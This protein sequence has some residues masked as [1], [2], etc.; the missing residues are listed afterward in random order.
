MTMSIKR[1]GIV[2]CTIMLLSLFFSVTQLT[3]TQ[4]EESDGAI[5][6]TFSGDILPHE[7]LYRKAK[8]SSGYNF[9]FAFQNIAPYL[10]GDLNICHLETTLTA[11]NPT[12]YPSFSTPYQLAS[13]IKKAGYAGC[14]VASNHILDKGYNGL[15]F[16]YQ[17]LNKVGLKVAGIKPKNEAQAEATFLI[18]GIKVSLL[19][20]TYGTNGIKDPMDHL[21]VVNRIKTSKI[22]RDASR[23]KSQGADIVLIYLHW[24]NEYQEK[25]TPSQ[26]KLAKIL[27]SS[28]AINAV[29]GSHVHV[30]QKALVLN[31]KP[32]VY[33]M[34]NFWSGQGSWSGQP[35]GQFG[36]IVKLNFKRIAPQSFEYVDGSVTP[37]YVK[38]SDWSIYPALTSKQGSYQKVSCAALKKVKQLQGSLLQTPPLCRP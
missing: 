19:A 24:G 37:T 11:R 4:A 8:T 9:D 10:N 27:L 15:N 28:P 31:G 23:I 1:G 20:Y 30:L 36:E 21:G 22:L 35:A 33:G 26:E 32:L 6:I 38:S 5:S 2:V 18:N 13:A 12:S 16:T 14:D 17:Q 25:P 3:Q 7:S 29:V 34:G